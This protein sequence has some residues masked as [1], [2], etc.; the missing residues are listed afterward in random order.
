MGFNYRRLIVGLASAATVSFSACSAQTP[1]PSALP[2]PAPPAAAAPIVAPPVVPPPAAP[3]TTT[4]T[5]PTSKSRTTSR[6][7]PK[8]ATTSKRR[9]SDGDG[10]DNPDGEYALQ[11][12]QEQTGMTRAECVADSAAGNAS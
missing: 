10:F 1:M 12:C 7:P 8:P 9:S 5:T 3:T 4:T 6:T 2:S 11:A